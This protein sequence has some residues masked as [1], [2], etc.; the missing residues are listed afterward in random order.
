MNAQK[1][2][3]IKK[4]EMYIDTSE[5]SKNFAKLLDTHKTY[6]LNGAWGTGKTVFLEEAEE[7]SKQ[8]FCVPRFMAN[9]R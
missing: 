4:K 6:F 1:K 7:Y 5:S 2:N 3:A 9:K 8:K